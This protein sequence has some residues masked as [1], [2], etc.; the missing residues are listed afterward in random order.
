MRAGDVLGDLLGGPRLLAHA[1]LEEVAGQ[2]GL[3]E[4]EQVGR[5][6]Q[7]AGL[8]KARLEL[9]EVLGVRTLAGP[10]LHYREA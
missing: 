9:R 10:E 1:A 8:A 3:G 6:A 4:E 5:F 2:G 7:R